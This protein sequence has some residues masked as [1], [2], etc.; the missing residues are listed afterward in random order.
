MTDNIVTKI[1]TA[2]ADAARMQPSDDPPLPD[3]TELP[4]ELRE[5]LIFMWY[6]GRKDALREQS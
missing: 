6:A 3:W 1:R 4:R 2:Y 5:V